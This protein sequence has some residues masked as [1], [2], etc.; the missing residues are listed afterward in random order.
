[1]IPLLLFLIAGSEFRVTA[2]E[3][4]GNEYF[5]HAQIRRVMLTRT[6]NLL[7]KGRFNEAV[8]RGDVA[9][10]RNLY[11]Y[12]GFLDAAV[13][14]ELDHDSAAGLV[15]IRLRVREGGQYF[16]DRIEYRGNEVFD[17]ESLAQWVTMKTGHVFDPRTVD[18]DNYII[19]YRYDDLGYADVAVVSE[20]ETRGHRVH[21]V[22]QIVEGTRQYVGRVAITGLERT[23]ASVVVRELRIIEGDL[24]RYA[25]VLESRRRLF[26]LGIFAQIR[27]RIEDS[28]VA[29][30]K[31][32]FFVLRE[33]DRITFDWRVGYGTRD[34]LRLGAG[35]THNNMLGRAWQ[36][37]LEGKFSFYER[38][39]TAQVTFPRALWMDGAAACGLFARRLDEIGFQTRSL[40]GNASGRFDVKGRE[41][42]VKYELELVHTDY[43]TDDSSRVDRLQRIIAGW[44]RDRRDDPFYTTRGSYFSATLEVSGVILPSDV[45]HLR[46][47]VEY[48]IY[49]P[50]A[51][52][53]V[54]AA[55]KAGL[56]R[57]VAPTTE[58]PVYERFYCGGA[59][60]VRGYA[61]HAIGPVDEND[62]PL[63]GQVLGEG[64][65]EL[66]FPIYRLL[67]GVLF[68]DTG[69][70][71]PEPGA[72]DLSLRWG[73]GGGVR[74]K[75]LLG[76]IRFDYGIK[77][78]REE[79]EPAG[80]LHFAI[81]EA[82]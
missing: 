45:D 78:G 3:I 76:S 13:D 58:I 31:D 46:P 22:H 42:S 28:P 34:R 51:G 30:H 38:R 15:A 39:A 48:R 63:G 53:V 9:A 66:R 27:V 8:F 69:N 18:A 36:G 20:Y 2:I 74:V 49:R 81:G 21:V 67:G 1:M 25:R 43:L 59:S 73:I 57:P 44:R 11:R 82:F 50:L 75:T 7:R 80:A 10:I 35:I 61:E 24:F 37:S 70:V 79:G 40:G 32:V 23:R 68:L 16:V 77:L 62:N 72:V 60:S 54:G 29:G 17:A 4:Q 41:V 52:F 14:H 56:V 71:W 55:I 26:R 65:V 47:V 6:R 5:T 12:N 64:S 19:R 33:R